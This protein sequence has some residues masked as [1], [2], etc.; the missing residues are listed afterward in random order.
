MPLLT[1]ESGVLIRLNETD[2]KISLAA[3]VAVRF[4][5]IRPASPLFLGRL[6]SDR[7]DQ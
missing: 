5:S 7:Q 2:G 3:R 6:Q 1:V 4:L